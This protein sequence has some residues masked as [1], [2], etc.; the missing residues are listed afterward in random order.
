M[1]LIDALD[2]AEDLDFPVP[3]SDAPDAELVFEGRRIGFVVRSSIFPLLDASRRHL[4]SRCPKPTHPFLEA[5]RKV[6]AD[7]GA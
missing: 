3:V 1:E 7:F 6:I 5:L 4:T 2:P